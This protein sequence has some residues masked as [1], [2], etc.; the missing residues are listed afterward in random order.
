MEI[1]E[2]QS[3]HSLTTSIPE[4]RLVGGHSYQLNCHQFANARRSWQK[5]GAARGIALG[6]M[7]LGFERIWMTAEEVTQVA[8]AIQSARS[9]L[10]LG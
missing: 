7:T 5:A 9:P 8:D 10:A 2:I 6:V 4:K 3:S 1:L